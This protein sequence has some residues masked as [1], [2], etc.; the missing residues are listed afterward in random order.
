MM[1]F[2]VLA[3][4]ALFYVLFFYGAFKRWLCR[5]T[6]SGGRRSC[7]RLARCQPQVLVRACRQHAQC[8]AVLQNIFD[9]RHCMQ[10]C[11]C[12]YYGGH[13]STVSAWLFSAVSIYS[14]SNNLHAASAGQ[15]FGLSVIS[16]VGMSLPFRYGPL[17]GVTLACALP[18]FMAPCRICPPQHTERECIL[19]QRAHGCHACDRKGCWTAS[20][21]CPFLHRFR[22]PHNDAE[23]GDTAPHIRETRIS[24]LADGTEVAGPWLHGV[25]SFEVSWAVCCRVGHALTLR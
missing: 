21:E 15:C 20:P 14:L 17:M 9:R 2:S 16:L 24:C 13:A 7:K 5:K 3:Y 1:H 23:M 6:L 11:F 18:L 19:F 8:V 25:G 4:V 12:Y 22:E 10:Y